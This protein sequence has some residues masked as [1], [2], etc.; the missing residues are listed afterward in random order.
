MKFHQIQALG[1]EVHI[2]VTRQQPDAAV[3]VDNGRPFFSVVV[4][5]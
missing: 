5:A 1:G 4:H 2:G 3:M